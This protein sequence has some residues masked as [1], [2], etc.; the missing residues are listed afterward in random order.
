MRSAAA[1]IAV[2]TLLVAPVDGTAP[3]GARA[4]VIGGS[5]LRWIPGPT[6]DRE[7]LDRWCR[8][9]GPPLYVAQ[10]SLHPLGPPD[11]R[12]LVVVTWNAHMHEGR[13]VDLVDALRLGELT[14]SPVDHF[15]LL[16][17]ELYRRGP[18]VPAFA[19]GTRSA[20]G[21]FGDDDNG[22][23]T[24]EA[25]TGLGLSMLYVPSMRNGAGRLEDRGNAILSTEPLS[26]A[27]AIELPLARQRRVAIGASVQVVRDGMESTLRVLD[28]HLEPLSSPRSLWVFRNPRTAQVD[29][30]LSL[31]TTESHDVDVS[32]AGTVVGGDFNTVKAGVDEPAYRDMRAW[33]QSTGSED[34]RATHRL[35]RLDYLFY[36]LPGPWQGTTRRVDEKFGSDHHPIVGRFTS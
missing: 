8:G 32:W 12:D 10:P 24:T 26:N 21:I 30:I 28:V 23:D 36:Q 14:G 35:G 27:L 18:D 16:V 13:L 34:R 1:A 4:E 29:S 5:F 22:P 11:L 3:C 7:A 20:H 17:Q 6:D 9:V 25:A 15:V 31:L 19:A 2:L 33:G